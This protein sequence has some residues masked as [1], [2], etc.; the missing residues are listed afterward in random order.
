MTGWPEKPK[1]VVEIPPIATSR[2]ETEETSPKEPISELGNAA[3][4]Q[5]TAIAQ[6]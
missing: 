1:E 2:S 4:A 3:T 5:A 6:P